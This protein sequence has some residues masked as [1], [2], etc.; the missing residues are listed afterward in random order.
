M[1][2]PKKKKNYNLNCVI[3][4][5]YVGHFGGLFKGIF[6]QFGGLD[7]SLVVLV[8]PRLFCQFLTFRG[9]FAILM[10][11]KY[12]SHIVGSRCI[13]VIWWFQCIWWFQGYFGCSWGILGVEWE[14][15]ARVYGGLM[16]LENEGFFFFTLKKILLK[17]EKY[18]KIASWVCSFTIASTKTFGVVPNTKQPKKS[19]TERLGS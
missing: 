11:W 18:Y 9:I 2:S 1:S 8:V 15:R 6:G 7:G 19:I 16:I 5:K 14:F 13:L 17:Q 10:I 12:F 3:L 4:H